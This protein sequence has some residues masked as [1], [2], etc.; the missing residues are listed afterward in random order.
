[1]KIGLITIHN[2][3]NYGAALQTYATVQALRKHGQPEVINYKN[4]FI[5]STMSLIRIGSKPRDFF[6]AGKDLTRILPRGRLL[7]KFN[8]FFSEHYNLSGPLA[9]D[10]SGLEGRYDAFVCG[11][12]QIW[13]PNIIGENPKLDGAYFLEFVKNKRKISYA[14][15]AGSYKFK[16]DE[17]PKIENYLTSFHK[18]SSRET[19]TANQISQILSRNVEHVLDPTLLL[20]KSE[21]KTSLH[22]KE[23]PSVEK[24]ILIYSLKKDK[25]FIDAVAAAKSHL[26]YKVISIDQEPFAGLKVDEHI[27]DAGPID[28]LDL[29]INASFIVT[30]SFHGA[31]FSTN[32]E[33][34]FLAVKPYSGGNRV[35]SLL[36]LVGL[37]ERFVSSHEDIE[38][39]LK[40][41]LD[42]SSSRKL[43]AAERKK[44][45][46]YLDSAFSI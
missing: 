1:M 35:T 18:L 23:D 22:L 34:P 41:K 26:G 44:S 21:W 29:F 4:H 40:G 20:D 33:I 42:F 36:N 45:N 16:E 6:R 28:F 38:G 5:T 31:A 11:S 19:D 32:F 25:L 27:R 46:E 15:S 30:N 9:I 39:A 17:Y 37:T 8:S 3:S 24:Y 43:L 7:R 14:S 10:L 2:A 13:N 12:D